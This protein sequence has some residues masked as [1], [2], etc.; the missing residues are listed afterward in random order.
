MGYPATGA[1]NFRIIDVHDEP[2]PGDP[3]HVVVVRGTVL[4]TDRRTAL[5]VYITAE[6]LD[7]TQHVVATGVAY[8]TSAIEGSRSTRFAVT[9]QRV[10]GV[11]SYRVV[12]TSFRYGLGPQAP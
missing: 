7:S 4:N 6:A 11:V 2:A 1:D 3:A 9:L 8:V 10:N 5:N 12:V